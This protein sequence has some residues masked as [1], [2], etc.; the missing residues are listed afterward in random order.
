MRLLPAAVA[1]VSMLV[2]LADDC[3]AQKAKSA[4]K[5]KYIY[6]GVTWIDKND[7]G[8]Y[9]SK[10]PMPR[11]ASIKAPNCKYRL[12]HDDGSVDAKNN[13]KGSFTIKIEKKHTNLRMSGCKALVSKAK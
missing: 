1:L 10:G 13:I 2:P 3:T 7:Y 4:A 11:G 9:R 12:L 8:T 5:D 6:N